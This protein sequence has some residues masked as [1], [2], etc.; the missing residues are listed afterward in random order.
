MTIWE[1]MAPKFWSKVNRLDDIEAC[2]EWRGTILG[3]RYG[4][5]YYGTQ[6]YLA[7]RVSWH[8]HNNTEYNPNVFVCHKC[9]NTKCVNPGHL[10]LGTAKDNYE[11]SRR[12][13]RNLC[14]IKHPRAKLN[15][16][17]VREIRKSTKHFRILAE[18]YGVS[19]GTIQHI[20]DGSVWKH[21]K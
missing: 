8:I 16:D 10:F 4:Q 12:K 21:V 14:G 9:D 5:L 7:H 15:E 13:G 11:D 18:E 19:D 17:Q 3:G 2:W 1:E 6:K 20:L